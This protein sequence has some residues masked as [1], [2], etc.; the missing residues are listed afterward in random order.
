MNGLPQH[1]SLTVVLLK[2]IE[3]KLKER[4]Y[5]GILNKVFDPNKRE[6]KRLDKND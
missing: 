3:R 5:G 2:L 6:V 4:F 1:S